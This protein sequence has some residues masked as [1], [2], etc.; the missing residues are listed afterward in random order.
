MAAPTRFR[1]RL[2]TRG[3]AYA[4]TSPGA[5]L[6]GGAAAAAGIAAGI[7]LPLAALAGA[8]A[9]AG[10]AIA[11]VPKGPER[12]TVRPSSLRSP[13]RDFVEEAIDARDRFDRAVAGARTG[14]LRTRLQGIADRVAEG[15]EESWR[16][17]TH[18]QALEDALGQLEPL[19]TVEARLA[20]VEAE[21]RAGRADDPRLTSTADALRSQIASTRRIGEV[22]RDTRDRLRLLDARLDESVARAVEL[23]LRAGDAADAHGL[24]SDVE[25]IVTEMES[26]RLALEETAV[27]G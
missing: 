21:R 7:A 4:V 25:A 27:A 5:I 1:D 2:L 6:A 8:V 26:L 14:P 10:V 12:P 19:A 9:Y 17:A 11:R 23:S 16:I 15:V 13:W 22:S 20:E 24:D 18:G 3:G